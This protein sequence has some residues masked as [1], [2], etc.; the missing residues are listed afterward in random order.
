MVAAL[1]FLTLFLDSRLHVLP[2]SIHNHL[3]THHP[4]LVV[5]DVTIASC[6]ALNVFSSCSLDPK[7]WHQ[8]EKNIYLTGSWMSSGFVYIQRKREEDLDPADLVVAD[9]KINKVL[10]GVTDYSN[11]EKRPGGV[12]IQ[13]LPQ[14][15]IANM[16]KVITSVDVLFG[17][18]AAEPRPGWELKNESLAFDTSIP[19]RLS[20]RRGQHEKPERPTPRIREDGKFK[21]MQ[22]ADLHLSTGLGKCRDPVPAETADKCEADPR[23][24]Q[25]VERLIEEEKPDLVILTGDQVNGPTAPDGETALFKYAALFGRHK[26]PYATIFGN[27]DDQGPLDRASSMKIIQHLPYSLSEPGPLD[28]DGVGNYIV[29]VLSRGTSSHSALTLYLLDTHAHAPNT[30]MR[31]YDW[32]R[33]SQIKWFQS[34]AQGLQKTHKSYT[35]IHMNLAFIHIPLTEYRNFNENPYRGNLTEYPMTPSYNSG[36][37]DV[38]VNENV[39]LLSCG[40]YVVPFLSSTKPSY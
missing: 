28:V 13:R 12:W 24:L 2:K 35:H 6:S 27:H 36:F 11:W 16:N 5:T 25:F 15:Q 37:K 7:K 19:A 38:L 26:I 20:I 18:D 10:G 30:K 23:T 40:Q 8:V 34:T 39:V 3:P 14:K 21:I 9:V 17:A 1:L 32:I 31:E 4:G 29:E 22:V 33:P